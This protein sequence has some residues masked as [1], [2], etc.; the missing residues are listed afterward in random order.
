MIEL[1]G[2]A[3]VLALV[4]IALSEK[5]SDQSQSNS[6]ESKRFHFILYMLDH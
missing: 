3:K 5:R 2:D 1:T 4:Q 6:T